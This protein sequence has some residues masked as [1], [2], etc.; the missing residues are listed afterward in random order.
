MEVVAIKFKSGKYYAG[1]NK[2][3]ASTLLGAQLYKSEK[4]AR[5]TIMKSINYPF[6][7]KDDDAYKI[8]KVK[9]EE[10]EE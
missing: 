8:V 6:W 4:M 2:E 9:L 1:C 10:I 7:R 3:D 5:V